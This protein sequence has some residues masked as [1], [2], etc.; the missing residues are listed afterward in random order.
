[1]LSAI[2]LWAQSDIKEQ[3]D[4][5]LTKAVPNEST[6]GLMVGLVKGGKLI[7]QGSRGSMNMAYRL[8]FNDSTVFGLASVTKQFTAACIGVLENQ[9]KLSIEDDIRKHI[10]ELAFYGD[11]IRIKHLLNHTSGIRNHN[12]LLDLKGFDFKH[13]GYTNQ[14]IQKLMFMQAGVNNAP[15]ERMLYSNTNYVLLALVI[16]RVSGLPIHKFSEKELFTPLGMT[17]TFYKSDAEAI[18]LN[19]AAQHVKAGQSYKQPRSLNLCVGAGGITSNI[20][21]LSKWVQLFLDPTHD[22]SYLKAFI[23]ALDTLNS[24]ES[25]K[26]ARGM[27]VV[28]YK[29]HNT[30]NHSGRDW[31]MRSQFICVPDLDLAVI[32]YSNSAHLNAVG[33]SYQVLDL[34]VDKPEMKASAAPSFIHTAKQLEAFCGTYQELNSDL[35]MNI[36]VENDTLKVVS[37]LGSMATPL[38]SKSKA[39]FTRFDNQSVS[40]A[41]K[42]S[43]GSTTDLQVDFSGAIFYFKPVALEENL[44]QNLSDFVGQFYSQELAVNYALQME[45][46]QLILS[47]PN[48]P[49]LILKE[50]QT[51]VLGTNRRT[52]YSFH[53]NIQGDII[54][55][56]VA[57]EGTVKNIL[58]E[59][60]D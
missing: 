25:M 9:G 5:I 29:G 22:F 32:V 24:G 20:A 35:R 60:L 40:Y 42:Q 50:I 30:Y 8:P 11:T 57:A 21:D 19:Q 15:G 18:I 55:F 14:M 13:R 28:P 51:D 41:F 47:Y 58:F 34:F 48:L 54:S 33:I 17:N 46:D 31:G 37:S 27:F 12:V 43:E 59:R 23:T 26:H 3:I 1:M 2:S 4:E 38:A 53:R 52:K 39:S 7:Y 56:S 36:F 16:K 10:P 45:G 44:N 49:R 6:P